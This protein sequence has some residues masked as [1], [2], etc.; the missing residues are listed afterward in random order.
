L[1]EFSFS[2]K[3]L[4]RYEATFPNRLKSKNMDY[5]S[6]DP[7]AQPCFFSKTS[8]AEVV[9][10]GRLPQ[11]TKRGIQ[12]YVHR[13]ESI[14]ESWILPGWEIQIFYVTTQVAPLWDY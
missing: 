3:D 12:L 14:P 7:I 13:L 5:R 8:T 9:T 4:K 10:T 1:G 2:N 6:T 11:S